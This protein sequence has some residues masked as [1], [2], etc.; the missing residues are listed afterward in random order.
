M[1]MAPLFSPRISTPARLGDQVAAVMR[2]ENIS[3]EE[4][5]QSLEEEHEAR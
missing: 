3:L 4:M 5:L 1:G 2:G